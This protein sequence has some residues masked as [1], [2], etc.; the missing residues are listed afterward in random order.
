MVGISRGHVSWSL[1]RDNEGQREYTITFLVE[2]L[3]GDGPLSV[4]RSAGLPAIGDA[5]AYGNDSDPWAFCMPYTEV[6]AVKSDPGEQVIF[7][8]VTKKFST[9][10]LR[11]CQ[12]TEIENPLLEPQKISGSFVDGKKKVTKDR[13]GDP[14]QT[15]SFEPVHVEV[16][17]TLPTVRIEQNVLNLQLDVF[18]PMIQTV[19]NATLWGLAARKIR[20][21]GASWERK[22]YGVCTVYYTRV[23]DFEVNFNTFDRDDV[24]D[25]GRKLIRGAWN[26]SNTYVAE[27]GASATNP[28]DYIT[29]VDRNGNPTEHYLTTAGLPSSSETYLDTV[30]L[31]DESNFS[32]LGIPSSL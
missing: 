10:P 27:G 16:P 29:G 20:L 17:E 15:T 18:S 13:N 8:N 4:A 1:S 22:F 14:I 30:E 23:F 31:F 24:P 7:W 2:A 12:S 26:D 25:K 9:I 11:R 6:K 3:A 21:A 5:W 19:N 32:L 28:A